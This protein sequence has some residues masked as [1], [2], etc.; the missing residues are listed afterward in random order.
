MS[1]IPDYTVARKCGIQ[2]Y[3]PTKPSMCHEHAEQC[4]EHMSI[5]L[6]SFL[7]DNASTWAVHSL[8]SWTTMSAQ[9][10]YRDRLIAEIHAS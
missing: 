5:Q 10:T 2:L 4:A 1:Y 6:R 3:D 8:I 7:V 9:R